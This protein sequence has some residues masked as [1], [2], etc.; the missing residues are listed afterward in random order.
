M[1]KIILTT[2]AITSMLNA[3]EIKYEGLTVMSKVYADKILGFD[4]KDEKLYNKKNIKNAI[5]NFAKQGYF[6]NIWITEDKDNNIVFNF[7]EKKPIVSISVS[8]YKEDLEIK[9]LE[10]FLGLKIGDYYD[11]QHIQL[12][13]E[14]I[15]YDLSNEGYINYKVSIIKKNEESGTLSIKIKIDKGIE[16]KVKKLTFKGNTAIEASDL[17]DIITNKEEDKYIGWM[18]GFNSGIFKEKEVKNDSLRLKEKYLE[19]GY[20]DV[21]IEKPT[22]K[23]SN[24]KIELNFEILEGK[25]YTVGEIKLNLNGE[26]GVTNVKILSQLLSQ[27]KSIFNVSDFRLDMDKIKNIL[28]DY[29]YAFVHIEPRIEKKDNIVNI[30]LNVSEGKRVYIRNVIIDGNDRTMDAVIRREIYLATGDL[31]NRKD[32]IESKKS[33]GRTG[34]FEKYEIFE[35]RVS[36]EKIDLEIV[37]KEQKTGTIQV[38]GGYGSYGGFLGTLSVNDRNIFGSGI[39]T[40][41]KLEKSQK[42]SNYSLSISNP[43]L[44]DS[45]YSGNVSV[46]KNNNEYND[47]TVDT[48]GTSFGVGKKLSRHLHL[49]T[50]YSYNDTEYLDVNTNITDPSYQSYFETYKKSSLMA[51]LNFNNTDDYYISTEGIESSL[52]LEKAGIG[53]D[54][55]FIKSKFRF[56]WFYS[57]ENILNHDVIFRYKNQTNYIYDSGFIPLSES[58]YLG[59]LDSVRGYQAYSISP[60]YTN[61]AGELI[62]TGGKQSMVNT[63]ELSVALSGKKLRG[64]AFYDNGMVGMDSITEIQK[65]GYGVGIEWISPMGPLKFIYAKPLN[66]KTGDLES[67]FEFSFGQK[68]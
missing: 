45:D 60:T 55:D 17:E 8:G 58:F 65:G 4:Y 2:L 48:V 18:W 22:I 37:V 49:Y 40:G 32:I 11:Q 5:D 23:K 53:G 59:G 3:V 30:T 52:M 44:N 43:K 51:N 12:V 24:E 27:E 36:D 66:L 68:F 38:G 7:E 1:K 33:L 54:A 21:K 14:K 20:L 25:Q 10:D 56:N 57:L 46:Y 16:A 6:N 61:S 47:Y 67:N 42:T 31:Y 64:L 41:I 29:G 63:V 26:I 15:E 34:F 62:R 28:G 19:K 50:A 39:T 9:E 13:K 35:K